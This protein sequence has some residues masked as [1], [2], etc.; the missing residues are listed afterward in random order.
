VPRTT[1]SMARLAIKRALLGVLDRY[2]SKRSIGRLWVHFESSCA[3]CERQLARELRN[4]HADHLVAVADGST[5]HLSNFVLSCGICNGDERREAPWDAFLLSKCEGDP[6]AYQRRHN[7]I[8]A[9]IE[10]NG[11]RAPAPDPAVR[12]FVE[13]QISAAVAAFSD[14]QAALLRVRDGDA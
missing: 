2:P 9:W 13:H 11:G 7:R 10:L 5:N 3:F 12:A 4:G 1:P 6:E 14:S 8:M